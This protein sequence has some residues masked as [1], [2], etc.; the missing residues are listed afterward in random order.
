MYARTSN[1]DRGEHDQ[2][3][4]LLLLFLF[5]FAGLGLCA[6]IFECVS[7]KMKE[8]VEKLTIMREKKSARYGVA[9]MPRTR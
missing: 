9:K 1:D 6:S 4:L 7:P 2:V 8:R 5:S 3:L